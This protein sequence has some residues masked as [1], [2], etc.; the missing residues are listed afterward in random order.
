MTR[1]VVL[2]ALAEGRRWE[3]VED[4]M[5][6]ETRADDLLAEG[7]QVVRCYEGRRRKWER[8]SPLA[9]ERSAAATKTAKTKEKSA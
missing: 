5:R 8:S 6:A 3:I 1:R 7:A 9:S 4:A 2:V